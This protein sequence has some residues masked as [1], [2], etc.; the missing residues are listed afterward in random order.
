MIE[1]NI[2]IYI[3]I[4]VLLLVIFIVELIFVGLVY[5][6]LDF[7]SINFFMVTKVRKMLELQIF[8]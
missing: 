2:Y 3:Y 1:L 4:F 6:V 8:L 5:F 7:K